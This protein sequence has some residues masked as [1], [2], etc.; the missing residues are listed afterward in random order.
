MRQ[1]QL[2]I[3][4]PLLIY[5]LAILILII[6]VIGLLVLIIIFSRFI[7]I[8]PLI[9]TRSAKRRKTLILRTS[10]WLPQNIIANWAL[11]MFQFNLIFYNISLWNSTLKWILNIFFF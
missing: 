4:S 9:N 5:L 6:I 3:Y 10:F 11:Q 7:F 1:I 2:R 8:Y